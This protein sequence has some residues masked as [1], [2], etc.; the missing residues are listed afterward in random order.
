MDSI[1]ETGDAEVLLLCVNVDIITPQVYLF[2]NVLILRMF[3]QIVA[4]HQKIMTSSKFFLS[5]FS[6]TGQKKLISI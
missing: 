5:D 3:V 4:F 1:D 6:H 2:A